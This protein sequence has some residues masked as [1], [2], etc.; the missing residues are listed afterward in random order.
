MPDRRTHFVNPYSFIPTE[1]KAPERRSR[2][3]GA[4]SGYIECSLEIQS[5]TF[6]PNRTKS[7]ND[8]QMPDHKHRVF[9]SYEDLSN[10]T[11]LTDDLRRPKT[12]VIP[13]SEIRGMIRGLY[14]PLT[15]SCF[16]QIDEF[17]LPYKRTPEPKVMCIMRYDTHDNCWRI[18]PEDKLVKMG[19]NV[20]AVPDYAKGVIVF[21]NGK[22]KFKI[23]NWD[24]VCRSKDEISGAYR[25]IYSTFDSADKLIVGYDRNTEVLTPSSEGHFCLHI[26]AMMTTKKIVGGKKVDTANKI[27]L[28][29]LNA[30][31]NGTELPRDAITR[32]E[33]VLGI[34]EN[35]KGGYRDD[36]INQNKDSIKRTGIYI[37]RYLARQPIIVYADKFSVSQNF[38]N[39]VIYLSESNMTKEFFGNKIVDIL[40]MNHKHQPCADK[41][42]LCPA[43]RLF[44]MIGDNGGAKGKLRFTDT[45][46]CADV[47]YGA[48]V[49]LD[50]LSSPRISST[51]FYLLPPVGIT[52]EG[53]RWSNNGHSYPGMWN[54]DYA[55]SY[56]DVIDP[57][58][59]RKEK[60]FVRDTANYSPMLAGRKFYWKN[61]SWTEH[62][63]AQK[64]KMNS[65]LTPLT[66]GRFSFRV[67]YDSLTD[68][69]LRYLVFCLSLK[70]ASG[71]TVH[72]IGGAKPYG[73]GQ[74]RLTVDGVVSVKYESVCDGSTGDKT[75]ERKMIPL[76][77]AE[78]ADPSV[79]SPQAADLILRSA[80]DLPEGERDLVDY[81]R[82][83]TGGKIFEWFKDNRG[84]V[85]APKIHQRLPVMSAASQALPR[86]PA[87]EY[88]RED[89]PVAGG[90]AAA[91]AKPVEPGQPQPLGTCQQEGCN[92]PVFELDTNTKLPS[93]YCPEC[94]KKRSEEAKLRKEREKAEKKAR[95]K[96]GSQN[97]DNG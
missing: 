28:F 56:K 73:F 78:F 59:G 89:A 82:K 25:K 41:G 70:D 96:Q 12:P 46:S 33:R 64:G 80:G 50:I 20:R 90:S 60:L 92:N 75:I 87:S 93:R 39:P 63:H 13:G 6:I 5:P 84:S 35:V 10:K 57:R 88:P 42:S 86:D 54:Y 51:E 24:K 22:P 38:K 52:S 23:C 11:E 83:Y 47:G 68:D 16:S 71:D 49:T 15:N 3:T 21:E 79:D 30:G 97:N 34:D 14:E 95:K 55:L 44:G 94:R 76:D 69:E 26:P 53:E 31:K 2:E 43:C 19:Q 4:N 18:T 67:Y 81:P 8:P 66:K 91:A 1:T 7:F 9:Y 17:N 48:E 61:A 29:S 58:T 45:T 37:K 77:T 27:I 72:R 74:C 85:S 65:S 40:R 62:T 32:F 36:V